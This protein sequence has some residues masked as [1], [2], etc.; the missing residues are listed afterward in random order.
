MHTPT[1]RNRSSDI[2]LPY[3]PTYPIEALLRSFRSL[4]CQLCF[5]PPA[6][7][8]VVLS[9]PRRF[10][11]FRSHPVA[12]L[13]MAAALSWLALHAGTASATKPTGT[14]TA[15]AAATSAK[16][17]EKEASCLLETPTVSGAG[18][19]ARPS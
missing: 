2:Y 10:A 3:V 6:C 15:T 18:G 13:N 1:T 14:G 4:V 8:C 11:A 19:I 12:L 17:E 5:L 7:R 9:W 16:E